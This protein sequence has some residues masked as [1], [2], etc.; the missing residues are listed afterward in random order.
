MYMAAG[1]MDKD[2]FC[3]EYKKHGASVLVAEYYRRITVLN[4]KF[5][6]CHIPL[7]YNSINIMS[8]MLLVAMLLTSRTA[9]SIPFSEQ[10]GQSLLLPDYARRRIPLYGE[11]GN[12]F[13]GGRFFR[14]T[15]V[16]T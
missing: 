6:L 8:R 4:G 13:R 9:L 7:F 10:Q 1:N 5:L 16:L 11:I 15:H 3:A 14:R 2:Q 12:C